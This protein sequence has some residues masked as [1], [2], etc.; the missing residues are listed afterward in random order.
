MSEEEQERVEIE[1]P[2]RWGREFSL[3]S[4]RG[5]TTVG[6]QVRRSWGSPVHTE[7]YRNLA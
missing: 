7:P 6:D 5:G 3:M 2:G 1:G 4:M